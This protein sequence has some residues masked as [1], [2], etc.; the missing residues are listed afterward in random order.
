[1]RDHIITASRVDEKWEDDRER[2]RSLQAPAL[3][4][5]AK[6]FRKKEQDVCRMLFCEKGL[7]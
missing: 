6:V 2:W 7:R 3:D 1:M 4:A 5:Q